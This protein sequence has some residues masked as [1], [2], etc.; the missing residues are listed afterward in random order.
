ML[1]TPLTQC[2]PENSLTASPIREAWEVSVTFVYVCC[3]HP[4]PPAP[5][6]LVSQSAGQPCTG[7]AAIPV[8]C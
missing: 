7:K 5:C 3:S 8:Q 4:L 1:L 6:L 2:V